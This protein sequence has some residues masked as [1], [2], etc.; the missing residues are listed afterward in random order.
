VFSFFRDDPS[1][2][3]RSVKQL[4]VRD[5]F[6]EVPP[7]EVPFWDVPAVL[8]ILLFVVAAVLAVPRGRW[9]VAGSAIGPTPPDPLLQHLTPVTAEM[10]TQT[11]AETIDLTP[12]ESTGSDWNSLDVWQPLAEVTPT[13][14]PAVL[15][16]N[17]AYFWS[18]PWGYLFAGGALLAGVIWVVP[19]FWRTR[20]ILDR[21]RRTLLQLIAL[22]FVMFG[23]GLLVV[24][25]FYTGGYFLGCFAGPTVL[26]GEFGQYFLDSR[27]LG[28]RGGQFRGLAFLTDLTN[29]LGGL[30]VESNQ[31]GA[32]FLELSFFA[33]RSKKFV[34]RAVITAVVFVLA[35]H[36]VTV[37]TE[38][39]DLDEAFRLARAERDLQAELLRLVHERSVYWETRLPTDPAVRAKLEKAHELLLTGRRID[40]GVSLKSVE[41][42]EHAQT[43]LADFPVPHRRVTLAE[44]AWAQ[45]GRW[46]G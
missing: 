36:V 32:S 44:R 37:L 18:M 6:P 39:N 22:P 14:D 17:A 43:L 20:R 35:E 19:W 16:Q 11:M 3:D 13:A 27:V 4:K 26:A 15:G 5:G 25:V 38:V 24:T 9:A 12:P 31:S 42:F 10:G 41:V 29:A 30:G 28:F 46:R 2:L 7:Q 45:L 1:E 40:Y 34:R 21:P 33:F 23:G 8:V